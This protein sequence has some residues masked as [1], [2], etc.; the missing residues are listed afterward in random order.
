MNGRGNFGFETTECFVLGDSGWIGKSIRV[1]QWYLRI[2]N[3]AR[4]QFGNP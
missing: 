3:D 2:L 1:D 4:F